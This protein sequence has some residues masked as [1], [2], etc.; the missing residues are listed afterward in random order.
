MSNRS[1]AVVTAVA[2]GGAAVAVMTPAVTARLAT[3][4]T[5]HPIA[6]GG[7]HHEM[8]EAL[9]GAPAAVAR[10]AP[11]GDV[12][13]GLQEVFPVAASVDHKFPG[14]PQTVKLSGE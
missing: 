10:E 8:A 13:I 12:D 14:M 2:V 6:S 11:R 1:L 3:V 7:F 9:R 5:R 4:G